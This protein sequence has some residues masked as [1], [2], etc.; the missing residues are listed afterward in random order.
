MRQ[1]AEM[2]TG[3]TVSHPAKK[4]ALPFLSF[5]NRKAG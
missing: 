2:V 1:L 4:Q 3:R 5:L